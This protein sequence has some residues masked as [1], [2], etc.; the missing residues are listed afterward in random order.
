MLI[1]IKKFKLELITVALIIIAISVAFYFIGY[2]SG[3]NSVGFPPPPAKNY[4]IHKEVID[5]QTYIIINSGND[6]VV[7]KDE[8]ANRTDNNK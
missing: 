7:F 8:K 2:A 3:V 6:L 5:S 4:N 1:T